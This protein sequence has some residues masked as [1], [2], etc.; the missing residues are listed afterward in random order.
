MV[1]VRECTPNT[2]NAPANTT[3]NNKLKPSRLLQA[4]AGLQKLRECGGGE[5]VG[6][7]ISGD[8]AVVAGSEAVAGKVV[9]AAA[10]HSLAD[11]EDFKKWTDEA[12]DAGVATFYAGPAAGDY[13][14]C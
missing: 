4:D 11:D 13:L 6:W 1:T 7:K 2:P 9:D 5:D 3:I 14:A 10:E 12:G 8:W